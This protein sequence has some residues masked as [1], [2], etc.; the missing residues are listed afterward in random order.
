MKLRS[1]KHVTKKNKSLK[2][3]IEKSS[4]EVLKIRQKENVLCDISVNGSSSINEDSGDV[5]SYGTGLKTAV[6]KRRSQTSTLSVTLTDWSGKSPSRTVTRNEALSHIHQASLS[7]NFI[8]SV[9]N[10]DD[11]PVGLCNTVTPRFTEM[12]PSNDSS[13][14]GTEQGNSPLIVDVTNIREGKAV[15]KRKVCSVVSSI[16]DQK[17]ECAEMVCKVSNS[18]LKIPNVE[19]SRCDQSVEKVTNVKRR[20]RDRSVETV[21]N[22]KRRRRDRSVEL[23]STSVKAKMSERPAIPKHDKHT[24]KEDD[25]CSII[26][27][28][29]DDEVV[30]LDSDPKPRLDCGST[31]DITVDSLP[32]KK[33]V[34]TSDIVTIDL[35]TPMRKSDKSKS[36]GCNKPKSVSYRVNIKKRKKERGFANSAFREYKS[37]LNNKLN[38]AANKPN[39]MYSLLNHNTCQGTVPFSTSPSEISAFTPA[40]NPTL[41]RIMDCGVIA[42]SSMMGCS[43]IVLKNAWTPNMYGSNLEYQNPHCVKMG[44]QPV[45]NEVNWASETSLSVYGNNLYN[46]NPVAVRMG[47]RPIVIDGSNIAMGYIVQYAAEC[48]GVIV[49]TDN[50]R[51]LLQENPAWRETIERRLLM[52]TWVGD[53]LMFPQD[54]LGRGGPNLERFLRFP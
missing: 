12:S 18:V 48:G 11:I 17:S 46:P 54:P 24:E 43:K 5:S 40:L 53:V 1:G 49:S 41:G 20:R 2:N 9:N 37:V 8:H 34:P 23:V 31:S 51:D 38:T 36:P 47:L 3:V 25:G 27:L 45:N 15:N 50:Y 10:S 39:D 14:R 13:I 26:S 33:F 21:T 7:S 4:A 35:C 30:I 28:G 42:T 16:L 32:S 52:F 22:V 19:R 6:M 29:S 44:L